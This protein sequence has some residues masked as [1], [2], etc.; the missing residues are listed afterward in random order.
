MRPFF[1]RSRSRFCRQRSV[2][3][4][5]GGLFLTYFCLRPFLRGFDS[6]ICFLHVLCGLAANFGLKDFTLR[7]R[8]AADRSPR[9]ITPQLAFDRAHARPQTRWERTGN[10]LGCTA[11]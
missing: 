4:V 5:G 10:M 7:L 2:L 3:V 9:T 1:S 11:S 6:F 8:A